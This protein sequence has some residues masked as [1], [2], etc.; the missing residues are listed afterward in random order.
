MTQSS[1]IDRI[2]KSLREHL[3]R[4]AASGEP[5]DDSWTD[6]LPS[7]PLPS[8]EEETS[9]TFIPHRTKKTPPKT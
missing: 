1:E 4:E 9:V 7:D 5:V 3:A 6:D 8:E 2:R